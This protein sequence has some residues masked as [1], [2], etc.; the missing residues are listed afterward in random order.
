MSPAIKLS[1]IPA[2]FAFSAA[3]GVLAQD[4]EPQKPALAV[5]TPATQPAKPKLPDIYDKTASGEKQIA[6]ALIRAKRENKRVL[7]QFGAN[8]CGWCHRLHNLMES[9][10]EIKKELLY[11]YDVVLIDVDKVD[12][13]PHNADINERYGNPTKH[14]LPVLVVL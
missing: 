13:K 9:D 6:E 10:K 1:L 7:L 12:G 8:W 2:L 3:H 14:G 4:G 11:E 5:Q